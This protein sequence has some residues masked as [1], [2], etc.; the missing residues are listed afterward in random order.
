VK[1]KLL[2]AAALLAALL[3]TLTAC[4]SREGRVV[5]VEQELNEKELTII[6]D[7]EE[8]DVDVT[9]NSGCEVDDVYPDCDRDNPDNAANDD[10]DNDDR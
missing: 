3:P 6:K 5:E 7:G 8:V 4:A 9:N 1:K 2:V 10:D